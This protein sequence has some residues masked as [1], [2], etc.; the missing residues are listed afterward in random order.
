[1]PPTIKT[2]PTI[3]EGRIFSPAANEITRSEKNGTT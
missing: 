2:R 3:V 1:M